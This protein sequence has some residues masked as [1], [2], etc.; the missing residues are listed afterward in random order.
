MDVFC[1][2][3]LARQA[4][5]MF[6]GVDWNAEHCLA[7]RSFVKPDSTNRHCLINFMCR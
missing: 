5:L 4:H 1:Q 2:G 6:R 3:N 7:L